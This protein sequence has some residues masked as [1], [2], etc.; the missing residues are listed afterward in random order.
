[1]SL[2]CLI[3]ALSGTPLRQS[4]TAADYARTV[5]E[6]GQGDV[7]HDVDRGVGDDKEVYIVKAGCDMLVLTATI[8]SAMSDVDCISSRSVSSLP[9]VGEHRQAHLSGSLPANSDR[10][11]ASVQCFLF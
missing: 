6:C 9:N 2:L 5:G 1:M 8:L 11:F 3:A 4:E 10:R 7:L